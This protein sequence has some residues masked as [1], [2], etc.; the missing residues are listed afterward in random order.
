MLPREVLSIAI[1]ASI[2]AVNL[3]AQN[4][5]GAPGQGAAAFPARPKGNPESISRGKAAYGTNCAYCH[6]DDARGGENGG[7][8]L[9][10]S[11]YLMKDQRGE[12]LRQ[13]LL[14]ADANG[15]TGAREGVLKFD[16]TSEQASDLA[17]YIHD[18]RLSSRDPG[19][20]RPKTIVVGDAKAGEAYF[21]TKC[22]SCHST[23]GDLKGVASRFPD[24]TTL[25][26]AWLM[27]PVY[28]P[29]GPYAPVDPDTKVPP[30]T[31]T[32][33]L[34]DG[35][36]VEGRLGRIDDFIVTMTLADGTARSFRRDGDT[37]AIEVHDPLKPH[38]DLLPGYTDRDIHNL[39]A[40]LVTLQ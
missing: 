26:Q 24:A 12:V 39:T 11:D 15:H 16:F 6:G 33:T 5:G 35:E 7:T 30:V 25:Q 31:V 2:A 27:P 32:V 21:S 28:G 17:A 22:A 29:R 40:Y 18:F 4:T 36:K 34:A 10:R 20:M 14:N 19:R 8:N 38:K 1:V 9:L 37:P 23:S 3:A 13:F